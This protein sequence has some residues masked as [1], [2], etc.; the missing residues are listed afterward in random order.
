MPIRA[1]DVDLAAQ[2]KSHAVVQATE[3]ADFFLA[4]RFLTGKLV[5]G[6][7]KHGKPLVL[8]LLVEVLQRRVLRGQTTFGRHIDH[9]YNLALEGGQWQLLS[10]QGFEF[11][12]VESTHDELQISHV[13]CIAAL[14]S[15]Q[16]AKLQS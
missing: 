16:P 15:L 4:A 11:Q 9:Q 6:Q 8:V 14:R 5:A 12:I 7:A 13:L 3:L 10:V 2:W 1:V